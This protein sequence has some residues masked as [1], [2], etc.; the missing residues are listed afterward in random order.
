MRNFDDPRRFHRPLAEPPAP[1]LPDFSQCSDPEYVAFRVRIMDYVARGA[2]PRMV[3]E[4][5]AEAIDRFPRV[6]E[7]RGEMTD[8][9]EMGPVW[10]PP[11]RRDLWEHFRSLPKGGGNVMGKAVEP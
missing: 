8:L 9:A 7:L 3:A 11:N 5:L 6:V 1:T 10:C 2:T 4:R